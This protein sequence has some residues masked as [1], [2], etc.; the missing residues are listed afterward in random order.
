MKKN[1]KDIFLSD[2]YIN[3]FNEY[4]CNFVKM[5]FSFM[6]KIHKLRSD[7]I[8]QLGEIL[9]ET[10]KKNKIILREN[11]IGIGVSDEGISINCHIN[12]K[13][14]YNYEIIK[15]DLVGNITVQRMNDHLKIIDILLP[16]LEK[17]FSNQ[18]ISQSTKQKKK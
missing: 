10:L 15:I 16:I 11:Q 1:K 13:S 9:L 17:L 3:E 4:C 5:H 14:S 18:S 6:N 12:R 8:K 7:L 2:E